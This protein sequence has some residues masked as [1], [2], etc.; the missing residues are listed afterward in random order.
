MFDSTTASGF[1]K[2][3]STGQGGRWGQQGHYAWNPP[4]E[5][6]RWR[7]RRRKE[8]WLEGTLRTSPLIL[9]YRWGTLNLASWLPHSWYMWGSAETP[10]T[11]NRTLVSVLASV[12]KGYHPF[13]G[14]WISRHNLLS[15]KG[16]FFRKLVLAHSSINVPLMH[17]CHSLLISPHNKST[18]DICRLQKI[19]LSTGYYLFT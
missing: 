7:S 18:V 16:M 12:P 11:H 17:R 19:L 8:V 6:I 1:P 10:K 3:L 4:M 14:A 9:C 2:C 5:G 13:P 15:L